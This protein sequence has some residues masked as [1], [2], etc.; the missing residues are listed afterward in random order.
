[1]GSEMCIRDR[2]ATGVHHRSL[3][4]CLYKLSDLQV[5]PDSRIFRTGIPEQ[6]MGKITNLSIKVIRALISDYGFQA[7]YTKCKDIFENR[8]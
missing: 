6:L 1:M 7:S 2:N 8:N 5:K 3:N 4:M